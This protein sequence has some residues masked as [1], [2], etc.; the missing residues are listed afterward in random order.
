MELNEIYNKIREQHSEKFNSDDKIFKQI[1]RGDRIFIGTAC[2]EPQYLVKA[3]LNYVESHPKELVDSE[4]LHVWTLGV[5][6]YA[7][8]KF[9]NNFR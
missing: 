7:D 2:G 1:H 3:L 8:A 5:A 4:I 6:P 9:K